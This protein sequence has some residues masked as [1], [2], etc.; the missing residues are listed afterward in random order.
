MIQENTNINQTIAEIK[1][2]F[3]FN[4]NGVT[5]MSM[6]QKGSD[7]KIN[8]GVP[9][10]ELKKT[11]K[12][13]DKNLD[14]AIALWKDHVRECKILATLLMPVD[15]FYE[16]LAELWMDEV[17]GQE[18]A[19]MY[20]FN[21]LQYT[22]FASTL[23]FKWIATDKVWHQITG[24]HLLAKLFVKYGEM[25]PRSDDEYLDQVKTAMQDAHIGV[26][27]AAM[28]SL[29]KYMLLGEQQEVN[30]EKILSVS[31]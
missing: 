26:R 25:H 13:F 17:T 1:K 30:G 29:N 2:T 28:A 16:E 14:L 11:A 3:R 31:N 10:V 7:Y 12:Q 5:S 15:E 6:R 19:E 23:A 21:L 4:M 8:W 20:A 24:Y 18:M 9:F 22:D 27:H